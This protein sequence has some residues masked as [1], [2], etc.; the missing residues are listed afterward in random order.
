L[1]NIVNLLIN[2]VLLIALLIRESIKKL[3]QLIIPTASLRWHEVS[4]RS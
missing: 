4:I 1:K 2:Q 3:L